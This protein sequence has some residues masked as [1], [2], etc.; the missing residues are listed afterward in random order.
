MRLGRISLLLGFALLS[1][2]L[3]YSQGPSFEWVVRAGA[4]TTFSGG[5]GIG[6][7]ASG[8]IYATGRF[9]G[10][11][12][13]DPGAGTTNLTSAGVLDTYITKVDAG[14][15]LIW[16]R[17]VGGPN[18]DYSFDVFV[19]ESGNVYIIGA[20]SGTADFDPGAGTF[21]LSSAGL[22]IDDI[23]VLKLDT[24]GNL[25][26]ARKIG[27]ADFDFGRSITVSAA[28]NVFTTGSFRGT[29][30]FDPGP[31]TSFLTSASGGNDIFISKL[32][33]AG[34]FVWAKQLG[35][36]GNDIGYA[37]TVDDAEKVFTTG[38]FSTTADFD[39]G[40]SV[41]NLTEVNNGDIFISKLDATGSFVWAKG[42]GGTSSDVGH[43]IQVDD[44]GNVYTSGFFH[45]TVDFDPGPGTVSLVSFGFNDAFICKFDVNGNYL[46]AKGMGGTSDEESSGL[47][48]DEY[49]NVYAT[50]SFESTVDFDPGSG[51]FNLTPGGNTGFVV[52]LD[53]S[54]D[55]VW[56]Q[57]FEGLGGAIPEAINVDSDESIYITGYFSSTVDFDIGA[58]V[59]N[60]TAA[61]SNDTFIHKMSQ[62]STPPTIT[63]FT[64]GSGPVGT[65]VTIT[66]T[67]FSATPA[68]NTVSF[69][70]VVAIVTASTSTSITVTVPSGAT[71]GKITVTV[72]GN[73]ATSAAD[74]TVT[75]ATNQP[76]LISSSTTAAP[77]NGI[78]VVELL[79]LLSDPDDNLDLSTLSLLSSTSEQG[80]AASINA[81][82]E[83][84]LDYGG[85]LFAGVD[86]V[87]IEVCDL[88]SACSQ[89]ELSIEVSGNVIVYNAL[90]PNADGENDHFNLKYIE[91]F[92]DTEQNLVTIYNRWGDV[93]WEGID[94][95]NS[96][97]VFEGT[98]TNGKDLP[99]GTYFYKIEFSSGLQ[100]LTGFLSLKR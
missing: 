1:A 85:V 62:P 60:V 63:S 76:P 92:P 34:N 27:G 32:D 55:F 72:A 7:D 8:N 95:D 93:V 23:F 75:T 58:G 84:E 31:G 20:F 59:F 96:T 100:S 29:V 11:V 83:L 61:G 80:A 73:T 77:I 67:N 39:P 49:G 35:G 6:Y 13:F 30:D 50:G 57:A 65:T 10:T 91:L 4:A 42:M 97:V 79:S 66:G 54:G 9:S 33:A 89:Q 44:N 18:D 17:R 69:N 51:I 86:R 21:N 87:S 38:S 64:P 70:G 88:L 46:W 43:S 81:S 98:S 94:Y 99:T 56:A 52:K 15:N 74:F 53:N 90:S 68:N 28:G 47:A 48:L 25:A 41:F 16:A 40:P 24:G 37:V 3:G 14:G 2:S 78:V 19:D 12:D 22:F 36:T 5:Y 71:T 82:S 45:T 26:W